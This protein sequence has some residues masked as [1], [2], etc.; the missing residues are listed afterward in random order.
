[1]RL[2]RNLNIS[3]KLL[4]AFGLVLAITAALGLLA[5]NRLALVAGDAR[6]LAQN[7]LASVEQLG[8]IDSAKAEIRLGQLALAAGS[9]ADEST[10]AHVKQALADLDEHSQAYVRL[11]SSPE[12]QALWNRFSQQWQQYLVEFGR[13]AAMVQQGKSAE[14]EPLLATARRSFEAANATLREDIRLN[15]EGGRAQ[16]SRSEALYASARKLIVT[17]VA[18]AVLFG[19]VL[20]VIVSRAITKPLRGAI[21]IFK[22][23]AAGRLDNAIELTRRDEVGV[24]LTNIDAMQG[25]LREQLASERAAAAENQGQLTAIGR[26]QAVIEFEL[27]GTIRTANDNFLRATGYSLEEIRGKHHSL[28]VESSARGGAEYR[29]FWERLAR[30]EYAAARFKR[31]GKDGREIWL[32]ASYNPILDS[33]GKP[34]KV[35]KFATDVT[36]QVRTAQA[37]DQAVTEAQQVARGAIAGDLALRIPM[38]AKTG[39]VQA[40]CEAVNALI[41][42]M[43]TMVD[44][45]RKSVLE[46]QSSADEIA[47]GNADLSQRTE[48]QASSLEETASSMEEMTGTVRSTADNA[49]QADQLARVARDEADKGGQVV[50]DA[51]TAMREINVASRQIVDIISV[52]DE[53]AF[54]T[55]L[56]A[57]NAAV[58]AARA[59]EQGRGFAVVAAEVRTLAGR[60]AASAKEIKSL[61][62]NSVHKVEEG[63]RLVDASGNALTEIGRAVKRVTDVVGEIATASR[64]QSSGIEQVNKAVMQMDE[65]T[66]Q[67]AALVEEAAAAS[68]QIASHARQLKDLV[69]R[70]RVDG[71]ATSAT[72]GATASASTD[73]ARPGATSSGAA[74]ERRGPGRPWSN[75]KARPDERRQPVRVRAAE[76]RP[77]RPA[78]ATAAADLSTDWSEF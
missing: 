3:V 11:I 5:E 49:S 20:A 24:L 29:T 21:D 66:Q 36:E 65:V 77:T 38:G 44:E 39:Q 74:V 25:K 6:E 51:V 43:S 70:Y 50:G 4:L 23:I 71:A 9:S 76:E 14:A 59:G 55:N 17:M 46:V 48:E 64:E 8:A 37:L 12:E 53:I 26:A 78:V 32:Q 33:E 68:E 52:I 27:D 7:W 22:S 1:M 67:N 47:R 45:I 30:G 19:T 62:E 18:A 2:I 15:V 75:P 54:Q 13:A 69:G 34:Y 40:L 63:S 73:G 42:A 35:V 16:S 57:L 72:A 60:S 58:E 61:I 31:V 56:L 28:F 41:G 10:Q